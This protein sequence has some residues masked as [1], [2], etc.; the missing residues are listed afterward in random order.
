MALISKKID[1]FMSDHF[2]FCENNIIL[3]DGK[4]PEE[5]VLH[6]C[7]DLNVA[8]DWFNDE[9]YDFTAVELEKNCPTPAGCQ[10]IPLRQFFWDKKDSPFSVTKAARAKGLLNFRKNKRYCAYCGGALKDDEK[11]VAKVCVQCERQYFPQ[12]EPATI[13][14]VNKGDKILL[15][16]HKN[17]TTNFYSCIAGFVETGETIE[18]TVAREVK[19]EV[20]ITVKNI[21]YV[22]SQAWPYPDQLMLA[23]TCDWESGEIK[24][25]EEELNAAAWFDKNNLPAIPP[26]GSVAYNLINGLFNN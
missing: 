23:F 16:N 19:E 17:R 15:A 1:R 3:Q 2:V 12:L 5:A 7:F 21:R 14:L 13:I 9:E 22:G 11:F 25:Q 10:E 26:E 18:E 8:S 4:L 24:I 20:G 6:R